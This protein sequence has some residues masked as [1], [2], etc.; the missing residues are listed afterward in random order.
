MKKKETTTNITHGTPLVGADMHALAARLFP[1]CRSLTGNGFRETLRMLQ[2]HIPLTIHEVPSGTQVFDWTVPR[3]WNIKDAWVADGKG[4]KIIEFKKNNLHVVG[5]SMPIDK[6]ITLKELEE[7]LYS[8]PELPDAIPY[9]TSY[10]QERWGF[11]MTHT[12]RLKLT[13]QTYHVFIDSELKE[14]SLTYGELIIKGEFE[15]EIFLSTYACHP[16]MANNELS[17]PVVATFLAQWIASAPRKF[18]YRIIF[19]PETIGSLTY[20]S[21]NLD[22]MQKNVIAGFNLTCMGDD[23]AYS[24]LPSRDGATLADNVARH[25][26]NH[27]HPEYI[28]YSYLERG[29]DE[30]QYCSP[31]VDLPVVS[32]MRS[33]YSEYPEYHTSLDD[34]TLVTPSGLQGSYDVLRECIEI[35]EHDSRYRAVYLGEPQLGKR[36]LYPTLSQ[37]NNTA[38]ATKTMV[39]LLAYADGEND[40]LGI[41]EILGVPAAS[42]FETADL[43]VKSGLLTEVEKNV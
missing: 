26:L 35:I 20:L 31:G 25:V 30:R 12:E 42:L 13:D 43:L 8:L 41:A 17:G 21:K 40:L 29:S 22:I 7:H 36:G 4:N 14:G 28:S 11:C 34:L 16:S 33:K 15:K 38:Y 3:E 6:K 23:R 9:T 39:D 10:Y 32:V 37:R 2:E 5:Y 27:R 18:T 1:I 19:I 24:F